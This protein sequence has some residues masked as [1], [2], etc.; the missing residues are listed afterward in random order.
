MRAPGKIIIIGASSGLGAESARIFARLG[1]KTGIIARREAPLKE[2]MVQFPENIIYMTADITSA[3]FPSELTSFIN[4]LGGADI[5][6]LTAGTGWS[7]PALDLEKDILTVKTD[8][9][10]FVRVADTAYNWFRKHN[11]S[12]QFAAISSVAGTKGIGISASYSASK[13]FN[14]TYMEALSQLATIDNLSL[15]ITD[16]KP[17]FVRTDL[18]DPS[19][20][21]P[22]L[23]HP[24]KAARQIVRAILRRKNVVIV[25]RKWKIVVWLWKLIPGVIWRKLKINL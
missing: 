7:N 13:S 5:I 1:W 19:R 8:V 3:T 21:Y 20:N 2:L 10:G 11:P 23:M 22:L 14:S 16:I 6:F 25:N 12:G 15:T 17:G 24:E 9:E 4:T 18:L